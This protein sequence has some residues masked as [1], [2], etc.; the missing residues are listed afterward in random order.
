M[1]VT[2][3]SFAGIP[4]GP[5]V[6]A[7]IL[8]LLVDSA[9]F[10]NSLTRQPTTRKSVAWPVAA[11]VGWAWL[12]ELGPF[13]EVGLFDDSVIVAV[14]K[15]GG[16]VKLS[17]E[18]ISDGQFNITASL[19]QILRDSLSRDLDLGLLNGGG[20]PEPDGV[21]PAAP[22]VEADDLLTGIAEAVGQIGDAG[23]QASTLA[24]SGTALAAEN[25]RTGPNGLFYPNGI[26]AAVGLAPVVVPRL[27]TPLVYDRT[28]A[29]LVVNGPESEV[30]LSADAYFNEDAI[31][32]R[33]K[34][35]VAAGIPVPAKT[36]RK[37]TVG[38]EASRTAA[39]KATAPAKKA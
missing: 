13:P 34:A 22:E 1:P 37:I 3:G 27:A 12:R 4:F 23:G 21:V 11:P 32:M 20:P 9:P 18:S 36:I 17:N 19:T 10:A 15:I 30:A 29:Y 16:I 33:L 28:R 38:D 39:T 2:T 6:Q 35:R 31:G 24:I 26:G 5:D 8:S 25:A 7:R 14:A